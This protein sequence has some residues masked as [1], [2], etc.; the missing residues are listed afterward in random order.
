MSIIEIN[1]QNYEKEVLEAKRPVV[2]YFWAP[3]C[4]FCK[5]MTPN[6]E[7][8]VKEFKG[9][10]KFGTIDIDKDEE[11]AKKN[12]L[13][14]VPCVIMYHGKREVGR[15]V[16]VEDEELLLEKIMTHLKDFY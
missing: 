9:D 5:H 16:G 10:V 11:L 14:G 15:I 6:F 4:K 8:V 3:W 1:Q 12:N 13:K 2:V 7:N